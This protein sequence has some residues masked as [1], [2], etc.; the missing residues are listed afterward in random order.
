MP[1]DRLRRELGLGGAVV[2]G[3]G[4][5][6]GTGAF[7]AIGVAAGLWG[8]AV[9]VAVPLAA[10]VALCN[11]LSSAYLAGRFPV[12]GGT[13][14]YAYETLGPPWG[15]S[16]GWLFLLA[17]SASAASAALGISLY[18]GLG[19]R[20]L[21]AIAAVTLM[22]LLVVG[23]LRGT[24]VVNTVLVALTT[25]ALVTFAVAGFAGI[26][27]SELSVP[28]G[29]GIG[30]GGVLAATAF[31]FVAYTGYGRIATLGEEVKDPART[32]PRAVLV[33][34]AAAMLLYLGVALGG[35]ALAGPGWGAGVES[36]ST[37]ATM[38]DAPYAAVVHV[39]GVTAM[40]GVLLNLVLG[41]SRVWLAMGRR[42]DMPA[43]LG[44]LD[45]RRVPLLATVTGGVVVGVLTLIGDIRLAWS[46]SAFSVLLYYGITNLAALRLDRTRVSAWAGLGS[47]VFLSFFVPATVWLAGIGLVGLGLVW[48]SQRRA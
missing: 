8:D 4:S 41:L 12:A 2:T 3:L 13:Y 24:T 18:L 37:P 36:G 1:P 14:E 20:R 16:A 15:F 47:C 23:G 22:T 48:H 27:A 5:I 6:L 11:G 9:L 46:F 35:R 25:T 10:A 29:P 40:L 30:P 26:G 39:G 32:I 44:T 31:L 38:L 28:P 43:R 42:G 34:L 17:K 45:Q 33:T 7:V 21:V 19:D